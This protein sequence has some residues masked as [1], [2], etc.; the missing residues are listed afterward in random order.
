ML[1]IDFI[2]E[3]VIYVIL[4][5]SLLLMFIKCKEI[6]VKIVFSLILFLYFSV[7][8]VYTYI[9]AV[10]KISE[11]IRAGEDMIRSPMDE[12]VQVIQNAEN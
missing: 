2:F 11:K 12:V 8:A 10:G 5:I 6:T 4:F 7:F 9:F 1:I 3:N